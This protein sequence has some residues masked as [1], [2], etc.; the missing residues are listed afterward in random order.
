MPPGRFYTRL[1]QKEEPE[2][3]PRGR[4]EMHSSLGREGEIPTTPK[5]ADTA[6][7]HTWGP[8]KTELGRAE[9]AASFRAV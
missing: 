8:G 4:E 7:S 2:L 5:Y 9:Q 3:A 1:G 6:S